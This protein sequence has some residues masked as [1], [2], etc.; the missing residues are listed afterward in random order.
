MTKKKS[1]STTSSNPIQENSIDLN[2]VQLIDL[3]NENSVRLRNPREGFEEA[4]SPAIDAAIANP[5]GLGLSKKLS[6]SLPEAQQDLQDAMA[7][8]S[9]E[10]WLERKLELVRETRLYR[11]ATVRKVTNQL[12]RRART[13][14]EEDPEEATPFAELIDHYA[15][16]AKKASKTRKKKQAEE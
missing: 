7:L 13:L 14:Q 8:Q 11:L 15:K 1:T 2:G 3:S 5:S 4:A 12:V 10:D 16:P 9:Y 6:Q